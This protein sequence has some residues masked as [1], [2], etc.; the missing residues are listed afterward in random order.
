MRFL[1]LDLRDDRTDPRDDRI[2]TIGAVAV[3][4]GKS[5]WRIPLRVSRY[6]Q[7]ERGHGSRRDSRPEGGVEEPVALELLLDYLEDG[8]IVGHHIGHDIGH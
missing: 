3:L 4:I 5:S 2:I 1:V 6:A 7:H 8:V